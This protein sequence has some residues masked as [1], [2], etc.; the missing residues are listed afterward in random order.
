[1][2]LRRQFLKFTAVSLVA[3]SAIL[4]SGANSS[5]DR[6]FKSLVK[7]LLDINKPVPIAVA[8]YLDTKQLDDYG[9]YL[10]LRSANLSIEDAASIAGGIRA[11]HSQPKALLT[12]FS[13]SY[14]TG[15]QGKGLFSLL[16][17]LPT[18]HLAALGVV[19]CD[20]D[21]D[22][23]YLI[24]EFIS[25]CQSLRMVCVEENNFSEQAKDSIVKAGSKLAGCTTIV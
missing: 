3:P 15:M 16:S 5:V 19:A 23:A 2:R 17:T 20:L 10:H 18:K 22:S 6:P 25:K 4:V 1:M 9:Y 14:N 11:L 12:S 7:A 8:K 24:A 21:D 13:V